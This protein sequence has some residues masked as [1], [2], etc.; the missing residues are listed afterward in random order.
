[1]S[2]SIFAVTFT[3]YVDDYKLRGRDP[4]TTLGPVMFKTRE[5]ADK[6]LCTKL[7]EFIVDYV[8]DNLD[9]D[10]LLEEFDLGELFDH[11]P[12]TQTLTVKSLMADHV[13]AFEAAA[14]QFNEGEFVP[15]RRSW[16]LDQFSLSDLE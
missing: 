8:S 12:E 10:T 5:A 9:E 1:M 15:C 13:P 14:E 11:N 6:F 16:T 3:T 4:S 2:G 7:A